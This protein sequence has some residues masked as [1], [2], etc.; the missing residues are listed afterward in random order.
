MLILESIGIVG[1]VFHVVTVR[2]ATHIKK[3]INIDYYVSFNWYKF[4]IT[5]AMLA[6]NVL[7]G[8]N[9]FRFNEENISAYHM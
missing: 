8:K 7:R 3:A 4:Y 9:H 1:M 2:Y 5:I 6:E